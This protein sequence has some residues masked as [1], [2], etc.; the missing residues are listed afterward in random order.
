MI[1][2]WCLL[3]RATWWDSSWDVVEPFTFF[4]TMGNS[5]LAYA[6]FMVYRRNFSFEVLSSIAVSKNQMTLYEAKA[7][8]LKTERYESYLV[9]FGYP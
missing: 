7:S 3:V 9:G 8:A 6:F 2:Q 5:I 4:I 1:T